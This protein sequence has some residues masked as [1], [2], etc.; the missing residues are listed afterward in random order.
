MSRNSK[1]ER[2]TF[3]PEEVVKVDAFVPDYESKC[4]NCGESPTVLGVKGAEIVYAS[5]MCGL[6]TWGDSDCIDPANW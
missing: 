1:R 6:C 2:E 5:G 3:A 4:S